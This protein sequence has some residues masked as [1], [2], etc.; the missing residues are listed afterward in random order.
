[1]SVSFHLESS[2]SASICLGPSRSV[3]VVRFVSKSL[4][5]SKPPSAEEPLVRWQRNA[6]T[7]GIGVAPL[8]SF[9]LGQWLL[10]TAQLQSDLHTVGVQIVEV[11]RGF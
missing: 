2:R 1:M 7:C 4:V 9:P 6:G 3:W 8:I 11:L 5:F 10:D